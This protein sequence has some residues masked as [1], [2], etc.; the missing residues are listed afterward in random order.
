MAKDIADLRKR[1]KWTKDGF[2]SYRILRAPEGPLEGDCDDFAATA[3]W[4]AEGHSMRRFW[5]AVLTFRAVFWAVKGDGWAS[6]VVL[7]HRD[8]G[9]ID[10]QNPRWGERKHKRSYPVPFFMVAFKMLAGKWSR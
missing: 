2:D 10:N 7:Y 6:H 1:F 9:W 5:A 4:I 3:L 8:F